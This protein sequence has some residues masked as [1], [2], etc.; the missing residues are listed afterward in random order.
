MLVA[1]LETIPVLADRKDVSSSPLI[2]DTEK[3]K[4]NWCYE[5]IILVENRPPSCL[6]IFFLD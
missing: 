4:G 5:I 1:P 2:I 3:E 6:N